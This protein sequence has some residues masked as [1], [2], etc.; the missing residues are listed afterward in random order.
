MRKWLFV[1]GVVMVA[2]VP[3]AFT[4]EKSAASVTPGEASPTRPALKNN[5]DGTLQCR[6]ADD[7]AACSRELVLEMELQIA[8][9][10]RDQVLNRYEA[11][12]VQAQQLSAIVDQFIGQVQGPRI[13]KGNASRQEVAAKL[14]KAMG[15]DP[16]KGDTW[17]WKQRG[18]LRKD[19]TFVPVPKPEEKK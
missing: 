11:L 2:L 8:R 12:Q 4:Q 9:D 5:S 14:I 19:G 13:E 15:G 1:V 6:L 10:E 7:S 18:L 16:D 17:D 3:P